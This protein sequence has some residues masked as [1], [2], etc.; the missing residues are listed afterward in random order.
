MKRKIIKIA[1]MVF[2]MIIAG[3]AFSCGKKTDLTEKPAKTETVIETSEESGADAQ[4]ET[5][6]EHTEAV[7]T[8]Y[9]CGAVNAA[10]VYVL[11][12]TDRIADAIKAA[13]GF[14]ENADRDYLNLAEYVYD[15]EKIYVPVEG[16]ATELPAFGASSKININSADA[17]ELK[18]LTGIGDARAKAIIDYRN[19][20]GRFESIE[21]IMNVPGIKEGAFVKIKNEITV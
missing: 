3:T 16:E 5:G 15:G 4:M 20:Y 1:A 9:V 14:A 6:P 12:S 13:G 11:S 19:E 7:C 2:C 8:V 18:K 21:S 10:D 17:E